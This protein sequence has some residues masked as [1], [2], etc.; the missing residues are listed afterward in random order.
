M[1][2]RCNHCAVVCI[3]NVAC[4]EHGCPAI[5]EEWV[6]VWRVEDGEPFLVPESTG[7][8]SQEYYTLDDLGGQEALGETYV[9]SE[10]DVDCDI[11]IEPEDVGRE[12]YVV[13][14]LRLFVN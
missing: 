12:Y 3:N 4:H 13:N 11:H 6:K 5:N 8:F 7:K 2:V 1:R 14:G 9:I 10:F